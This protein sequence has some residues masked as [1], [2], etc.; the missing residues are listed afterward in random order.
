[1]YVQDFL[2][3]NIVREPESYRAVSLRDMGY[4]RYATLLQTKF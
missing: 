4:L 3:R 2:G 1:M